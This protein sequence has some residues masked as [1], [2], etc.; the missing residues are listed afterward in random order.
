MPYS[1]S[2]STLSIMKDCP[3]CFWLQFRKDISIP[4]GV[5]PS[6]PSGMD[7]IIKKYFDELREKNHVPEEIKSTGATLFKNTDL[8]KIWRSNFKGLRWQDE[9]GNVLHGAIDEILEK[10]GKLIVLDFKTR[11]F[12]LKDDTHEHYQ[13]QLD[14][15]NFLLRKNGY[16]TKD[17]SYLLF[18]HPVS[19]EDNGNV[20]FEKTLKKVQINVK[21]AE[22]IFKKAVEILEGPEPKPGRECP[23]CEY[24]IERNKNN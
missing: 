20:I 23:V 1:L 9:K 14:I 13:D 7:S 22:N 8:L 15:Y 3:L 21:N 11:G 12:A 2:P 17:Y 4:A 10:D 18:F 16:S 19:M 6:L 24:V 5:F